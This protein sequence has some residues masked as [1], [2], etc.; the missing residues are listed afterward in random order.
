MGDLQAWKTDELEAMC[1]RAFSRMARIES[2]REHTGGTFYSTF[3]V[4]LEGRRV[5]LRVAPRADASLSWD[6]IW[7][8]RREWSIQPYFASIAELMPRTLIADFTGQVA[9]Q[10]YIFQ[11]FIEGERW[12]E[13]AGSLT[14]VEEV[15]LWRQFGGVVRA[16]HDTRCE[17]FG[18]PSPSRQFHTWS[19]AVIYYLENALHSMVN[20]KLDVSD[21]QTVLQVARSNTTLLDEV[22]RPCLLHGHLWLFNILVRREG[23]G[24]RIAAILDPD[25]AR[26]GD[27]LAAWTMFVMAKSA[28]PQTRRRYSYFRESYG[29][30]EQTT[31]AIFRGWI[32]EAMHIATAMVWA[33]KQGDDDTLQRGK[34][35]LSVAANS[36]SMLAT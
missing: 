25:R 26:W 14:A 5:I 11:T 4:K 15:Q 33:V 23:A 12:D 30:V 22:E 10:D 6:K 2:I 35:E 31:G 24:P 20:R 19:S 7:L 16:M 17:T 21:L 34:T 13:I 18:W 36:L 3:L 1:R 8:M 27:P 32:Y 9:G 29:P 28:G